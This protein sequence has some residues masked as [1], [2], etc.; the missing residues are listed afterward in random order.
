MVEAGRVEVDRI[1]PIER[2][3]SHPFPLSSERTEIFIF[4]VDRSCL[5]HRSIL[6]LPQ[7]PRTKAQKEDY[8]ASPTYQFPQMARSELA[9]PQTPSWQQV[10]LQGLQLYHHDRRWTQHAS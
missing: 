2:V 9:S 5:F 8:D 3:I 4:T 1:P 10:P 6:I 7:C